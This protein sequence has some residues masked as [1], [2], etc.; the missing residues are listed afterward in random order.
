MSGTYTE[1]RHN[2]LPGVTGYI[3][4][5]DDGGVFAGAKEDTA[6]NVAWQP[7][8]DAADAER[9]VTDMLNSIVSQLATANG[10][11]PPPSAPPPSQGH[12][13]QQGYPPQQYPPYQQP[14]Q[15]S[16]A[17]QRRAEKKARNK[18]FRRAVW[19]EFKDEM[20]DSNARRQL[21]RECLKYPCPECPSPARVRCVSIYGRNTLPAPHVS[22]IE[23]YQR[24]RG[25]W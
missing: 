15:L 4:V 18:A 21:E 2:M 17:E 14:Y 12:V 11:A 3:Y 19:D 9:I 25:R 24:Q 16:P 13:P 20:R 10:Y 22:R 7:A 8:T 5:D 6:P 23:Q 1:V